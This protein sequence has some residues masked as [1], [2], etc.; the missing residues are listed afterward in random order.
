MRRRQPRPPLVDPLPRRRHRR[1]RRVGRRDPLIVVGLRNGLRCQ[2]HLPALLLLLGE[3]VARHRLIEVLPRGFEVG[4]RVRHLV[5]RALDGRTVR[6]LRNRHPRLLGFEL[7]LRQGHRRPRA[8]ERYLKIGLIQLDQQI[9]GLDLLVVLD[10]NGDHRPRHARADGGDVPVDLRV[11]GVLEVARVQPPD[12]R[13][14]QRDRHRRDGDDLVAAGLLRI[15]ARLR[16]LLC[17]VAVAFAPFFLMDRLEG[18][19]EAQDRHQG[20]ERYTDRAPAR[21]HFLLVQSER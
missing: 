17:V 14:D 4:L 15:L 10:M 12:E 1:G 20:S 6:S 21:A 9:A 8:G 11:V 18:E 7:R 5:L 2:E 16:L 3:L 19:S 13:D